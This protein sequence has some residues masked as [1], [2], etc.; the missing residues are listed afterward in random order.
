MVRVTFRFTLTTIFLG[1]LL[2]SV[3][4]VAGVSFYFSR[5]NAE[6]LSEQILDQTAERI[7]LH[8]EGLIDTAIEQ[9]KTL[10][11]LLETGFLDPAFIANDAITAA[12]FRKLGGHFWNAMTVHESLAYLSL[13]IPKTGEYIF[14]ERRSDGL[15]VREHQQV[16]ELGIQIFE[17]DSFTPDRTPLDILPDDG[18]D[19]RERPFYKTATDAGTAAWTNA[20]V[21]VGTEDTSV[22][23]GITLT[24]PIFSSNSGELIAVTTADF[25]LRGLCKFLAQVPVGSSG[26]AFIMET[27]T[28]GTQRV[29]AHPDCSL[30]IETTQSTDGSTIQNLIPVERI[31]DKAIVALTQ[32]KRGGQAAKTIEFKVGN[33]TYWGRLLELE[34]ETKPPWVIG[35]VLPRADVM[36]QVEYNN[37]INLL[38]G[39]VSV[40]ISA[41]L[42]ASVSKSISRPLQN[43][44]KATEEIGQFQ[45]RSLQWKPSIIMEIERL[46][47]TIEETKLSLRSFQKYVPADLVRDLILNGEEA[48]LGGRTKTLTVYFSDIA[49]FTALSEQMTPKELVDHVGHYLGKMSETILENQ[50]TVDK[51]IGDAVMAFWGAPVENERHAKLAC[52]A[53]LKNQA[54]LQSLREDWRLQKLPIFHDRI[55]IHTGEVIVGNIGSAQRM[56][57]TILGD[58]VNV[59]QRLESLNKYYGTRILISQSTLDEVRDDVVVR[60]IDYIAVKGRQGAIHVYE[61][62]GWQGDVD[63]KQV[64]AAT[65]YSEALA[66]YHQRRWDDALVKYEAYLRDAPAD[67]AA[68]VLI[69]R[70]QY[71]K[72]NPPDSSWTGIYR[73]NM[74]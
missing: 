69:E 34:G 58:S 33:E 28:D 51:Y 7:R 19:P 68:K 73:A 30:L 12:S 5:K 55:G 32:T 40:I 60:H 6:D 63:L 65:L 35:L 72:A 52:Q 47:Q 43:L 1:I 37:Q 62:I 29:I 70:C 13:A 16:N 67:K 24:A 41:F 44:A 66:D 71:Y 36:A 14:V 50:G 8:T 26:F 64:A 25:Q 20:Y 18:Y 27:Q 53:A 48:K 22:T 45:L 10:T 2:A 17:Y 46:T 21:F 49:N 61:L 3:S 57:Y 56:N 42:V 74:K 9:S 54:V 31:Q 11:I 15:I 4:S 59:A 38:L 23:P 39:L